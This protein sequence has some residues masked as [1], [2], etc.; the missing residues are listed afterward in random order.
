MNSPF[1][2]R[3][4][5]LEDAASIGHVQTNAWK[6]TYAGIV[7]QSFL[8]ELQ[9]EPRIASAAKRQTNPDLKDFVLVESVSNK[10][11]GFV[12]VG[13]NREKNVD[14]DGELYAIYILQE[15]QNCGG[16]KLLYQTAVK[17]IRNRNF[18]KM[19]VSVLEDNK[20]SRKFY[21]AMGGKYIGADHVDIE[22]N[23]YKTATYL[24]H[25]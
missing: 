6:T 18:T 2:V 14:A 23:R 19:M 24:W 12:L 8:D 15:Y 16:G 21:E 25:F 17:E 7:H 22:Q 4:A 5:T 13:P 1:Y 10:V 20:S 3:E 9:P 11:V